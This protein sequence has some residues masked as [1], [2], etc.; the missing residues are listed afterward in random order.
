MITANM[1]LALLGSDLKAYIL[2]AGRTWHVQHKVSDC[3]CE[4]LLSDLKITV[5]QGDT[6]KI[7]SNQF[8]KF[9]SLTIKHCQRS[10]VE[11]NC[12]TN[13]LV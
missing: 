8:S 10:S 3:S 1:V 13:T 5:S 2:E 12:K 11:P 9:G 6:T 4:K 7:K